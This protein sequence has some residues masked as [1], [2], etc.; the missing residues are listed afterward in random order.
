MELIFWG[1]FFSKI[2]LSLYVNHLWFHWCKQPSPRFCDLY[3]CS[4]LTITISSFLLQWGMWRIWF[5]V[6]HPLPLQGQK[7]RG[8][9]TNC[10]NRHLCSAS[11]FPLSLEFL[12][13]GATKEWDMC[14]SLCV[15]MIIRPQSSRDVFLHLILLH[16]LQLLYSN[17]SI[18]AKN[19]AV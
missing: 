16:N 6:S 17:S 2:F 13:R 14:V 12:T 7:K 1:V 18:F 9:C 10:Q 11:L 5:C 19:S 3:A 15:K 8:N 4:K